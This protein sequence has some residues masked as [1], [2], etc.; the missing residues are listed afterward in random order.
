MGA[1]PLTVG[2]TD[3]VRRLGTRKPI[4]RVVAFDDVAI[5]TARVEPDGDVVADLELE[6][7]SNGI[8]A[9]GTVTVPWE[10]TCRRCL[11]PVHGETLADV[12]EVFDRHPVEGE[13][14]PLAGDTIDLEP[15]VRDAVVLALPLA[16][17]CDS[18][19][20]GPEPD[21]FP[22]SVE[23]V[24]DRPVSDRPVG[25]EPVD[26]RWSALDQ[27]KFDAGALVE[28][29][30]IDDGIAGFEHAGFHIGVRSRSVF[31]VG[32]PGG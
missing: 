4:R 19:C 17:L 11:E 8:V 6:S 24:G 22:T 10:G 16:P 26:P 30:G 14:Y 1:R 15:M 25:D 23:G 20:Q 18:G 29:A 12:R 13:T 27:L 2:V 28:H 31:D 3:L 21:E 5:S 9:S 32:A 7:I